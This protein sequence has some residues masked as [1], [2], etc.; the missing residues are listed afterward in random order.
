MPDHDIIC[1]DDMEY[2]QMRKKVILDHERG[3]TW[4]DSAL[5]RTGILIC[6]CTFHIDI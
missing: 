3:F 6:H 5:L 4:P 1:E 2:S